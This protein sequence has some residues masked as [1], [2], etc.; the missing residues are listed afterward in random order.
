MSILLN[1]FKLEL[2]ASTFTAYVQEMPE[3]KGLK[4]LRE[5]LQDSWFIHWRG[6]KVY[7]IPKVPEPEQKFGEPVELKCQENLQLLA[8]RISSVF[9]EIFSKYL[10]FRLR[11]FTFL[12]QKEEFVSSITAKLKNLPLLLSSFKIKPKFTLEAKLV[13]LRPEETFIGL[14]LRLNTRW[15]ILAPL[16]ELQNAGVNLQDLCVVRRNTQPGQRRLIGKIS[17]ISKKMVYLSE[18]FD[19]ITSISEDEVWL[20][21]SK[22]SFTRCLKTLLANKYEAF[23]EERTLQESKLLIG[24]KWEPLVVAHALIGVNLHYDP[25]VAAMLVNRLTHIIISNTTDFTRYT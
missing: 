5:K 2:S 14:F 22:S 11:P 12:A 1:G 8:A 9:P 7:G 6:G 15:E 19:E 10:P 20:E 3:N 17:H 25:L 23:E 16:S 18:S 13:E 24:P 4:A 21:G